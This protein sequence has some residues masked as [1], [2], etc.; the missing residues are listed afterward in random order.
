MK[1]TLF[2][3]AVL[4]LGLTGCTTVASG[5]TTGMSVTSRTPGALQASANSIALDSALNAQS[6]EA[7]TRYDARNPRETLD[8]FGITPGM[9]VAEALPGGG[10]YSK[11]LLRYL[12]PEGELVGAHY[13]N[14]M[15][16]R[17]GFGDAFV[18]RQTARANTW[19]ATATEWVPEGGAAISDYR[20]TALPEARA[21]TFDAVL[22]IRALHNLNRFNADAGYMDA[23]LAE[24]YK[25]LKPGGI[26]GVVQHRAPENNSDA[27]SDGANG[28]LKQSTVVAAFEAAGFEL[29]TVSEVNANPKDVPG[30]DDFVWRLAPSLSGTE[31]GTP[32]RAAMAAIGE[33][34][35][36]TLVFKKP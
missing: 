2:T 7:K 22:F 19:T 32:E 13:P 9:T 6:D 5:G 26:V 35:R 16:P 28:Y 36:M 3:G 31:E 8:V 30:E 27:W 33:S 25:A 4:A 17:F 18:E 20:L 15:W 10:W 24:T 29:V 34:D 14:D 23:T 21:G 11:I 1:T 12:G